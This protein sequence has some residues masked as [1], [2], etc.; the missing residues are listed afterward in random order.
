M[1]ELC[2]CRGRGCWEG[3]GRA[4]RPS[5]AQP[6]R[7]GP[8]GPAD[9]ALL[10]AIPSSSTA[11]CPGTGSRAHAGG[12]EV[13]A[14]SS[15][16]TWNVLETSPLCPGAAGWLFTVTLL[17]GLF[18]Q[19]GVCCCAPA[20]RSPGATTPETRWGWFVLQ[21]GSPAGAPRT[22][23]TSLVGLRSACLEGT[24]RSGAAAGELCGCVTPCLPPPLS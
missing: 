21:D 7:G 19:C 17:W 4:E 2:L 8:R 15:G 6:G 12:P 11:F 22:G 5:A 18:L 24:L 13:L 1:N 14:S 10:L 23:V 16:S 20:T 9:T 3:G